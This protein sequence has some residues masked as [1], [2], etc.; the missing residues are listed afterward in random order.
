MH[1]FFEV[2][3]KHTMGVHYKNMKSYKLSDQKFR[4]SV[5]RNV[6]TLSI[7]I[8]LQILARGL[9]G[10]NKIIQP[11]KRRFKGLWGPTRPVGFS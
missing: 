4:Q 10:V 6:Y 9:D 8:L 1:A 2:H 3:P 11:G 7:Y 5:F